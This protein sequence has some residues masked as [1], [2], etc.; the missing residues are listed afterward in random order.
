MT[1]QNLI[2][3]EL[4]PSE[5]AL[6]RSSTHRSPNKKF[7]AVSVPLMNFTM[8]NTIS[9]KW[10]WLRQSTGHGLGFADPPNSGSTQLHSVKTLN[11]F[12]VFQLARVARLTHLCSIRKFLFASTTS[13]AGR[14][15]RDIVS[16][17]DWRVLHELA[18]AVKLASR[19]FHRAAKKVKSFTRKLKSKAQTC[20]G[21]SR[22]CSR[23]SP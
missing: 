15:E 11:E 6:S 12:F 19:K 22:C 23:G 20:P 8:H 17:T 9:S 14:D 7:V 10:N 16:T 18:M 2:I 1:A 3:A 5:T 4:S 21:S 13:V